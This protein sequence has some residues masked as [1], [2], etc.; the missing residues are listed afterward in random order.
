MI[1]LCCRVGEGVIGAISAVRA[2]ALLTVATASTAAAAADAATA[3]ALGDLLL[4]TGGL[5]TLIGSTCFAVGS[6]LYCYL[7]LMVA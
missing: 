4:K 1:A 5:F 6:T 3:Q 2:L 7:C